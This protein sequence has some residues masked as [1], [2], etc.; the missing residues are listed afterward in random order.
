[1]GLCAKKGGKIDIQPRLLN[2]ISYEKPIQNYNA[3][4]HKQYRLVS[5]FYDIDSD[6]PVHP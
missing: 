5:I 3:H 6:N 4:D 2:P 1:V